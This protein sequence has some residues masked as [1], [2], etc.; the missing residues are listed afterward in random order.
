M[1]KILKIALSFVTIFIV[2]ILIL[3]S[4]KTDIFKFNPQN[5]LCT[6]YNEV[7][8]VVIKGRISNVLE[9]RDNHS[10][11]TFE[12]EDNNDLQKL[13]LEF[14]KSGLFE[15]AQKGDSLIKNYK[16]HEVTIIRDGLEKTFL[17][18]YGCK[19]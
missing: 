19:E 2:L 18:D 1:N 6:A 13:Y 15:Y 9:D 5:D 8:F 14:D 11:N 16:E 4:C 10:V 12:I 7:K 3:R 17:L